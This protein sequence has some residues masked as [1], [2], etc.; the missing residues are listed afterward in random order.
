[1]RWFPKLQSWSGR[2]QELSEELESH[3]RMAVE[4]RIASGESPGEARAGALKEL[5]NVALIEDVTR[6]RW[7]WL[8]FEHAIHDARYAL[9]RLQRSPGFTIMVLLTLALGIGANL[10]VFQ[11]LHS[12]ILA[13]LPIEH[14]EDV[15]AVRA[16]KTPFDEAWMVSYDA[17]HRLRAGTSNDAPLAA[18]TGFEEAILQLAANDMQQARYELVSEN[19][20][21]VLG[22]PPAAGRLF[23]PADANANHSE[24]PAVVRYDFARN[25]FGSATQ[26]VGRHIRLNGVP[27]VVVGVADR[28]FAGMITGYAPDFWLP[29]EA[30]AGNLGVAF[31]SLG[32]G[33]HLDRSW[34]D[35]PGIFWLSLVA[36]V[37][38]D[39]R[40][41][42]AAQWNQVFRPDRELTTE[43]TDDPVAKAALL[44]NTVEIVPAEHGLGGIRQQSS[45]PLF[46]L[47]ALS[48]SIFLVGCLN[49]ANL[50][51][52]RLSTRAHELGIRMALGA[53]PWRLARQI[54]L[55]D[56]IL[57]LFGGA[58]A[59]LIGRAA[60]SILVYW[61][62]T[63]DWLLNIDLHPSLPLAALGIALMALAL[64]AFSLLPA[65]YF[66]RTS[67][68]QAAGSRAKVSGLA[69]TG[70]QRWRAN[71]ML[72]AQVSLSLL[73]TVMSGCFAATLVHWETNDLGM[74]REHVLSVHVEMRRT[75]Y[76]DRHHD[77]IGL[78]HRVQQRLEALPEVR[79]A[80]VEM[81][82]MPQCGWNTALYVFGHSGLS[83]AQVH[84]EEDHVGPGFFTTM[85]IPLL[86]GRDFAST[87]TE[88]TQNVAILSRSYARQLFGDESPIGHRVGYEPAPND[89][90]FLIIG[91][92]AD[93]HVD[94]PQAAAPP[95]VY[96][97]I[98]Q[99]P[100]PVHA[101]QVRTAGDPLQ[102]A[103]RI[104]AAI[105]Q[106][107]PDLP[108]T[109]IVP[110]ATEMNDSLGTEKLLA[111]LASIYAGLTLLLV[112]IGFY[113]VM[114]S[115]TSRRKSE[116]GIRLAL[117]ASRQHIRMLVVKQ[118]ASILLAGIVPGLLLSFLAIR[119]ARHLL[120]GSPGANSISIVGAALVLILAGLLA[121]IIPSRRAGLADPLET[122]RSE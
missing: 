103:D 68:A 13:K 23:V 90:K 2:K 82:P 85:G 9:R 4:D 117:G 104:R 92:V 70:M 109:E 102:I 97:S 28:R 24:W 6:E 11:L 21:G 71:T 61:A 48:G 42:V 122:L 84:G 95:V 100:F 96:M 36:R 107:D 116:F 47:M 54:L 19:Y 34:L 20:F 115:R 101:I 17:Y 57:V 39:R 56:A 113:G 16:A 64:S 88:K 43:A 65:L 46:L 8:W 72:A 74:D 69:Q 75:G 38:A 31:D 66:I 121:S 62:S 114:S 55:E 59:F 106:V 5:G 25:Y 60:S 29:L 15:V 18:R 30:Q 32:H 99:N 51:V 91:E 93:A 77:W 3:L 119:M 73:L 44:R 50:Q 37:P 83:N 1:M 89:H 63:R 7:G 94:G 81:C 110:L 14:P 22:V 105:R 12:I 53:N 45:R 78:Y 52:A 98:E 120:F 112:G 35:Q 76:I 49:L 67:L 40:Q 10:A 80:S 79:A 26:A 27:A 111:R 41:A 33:V 87:D 58:A 86:R 108:I 118:T